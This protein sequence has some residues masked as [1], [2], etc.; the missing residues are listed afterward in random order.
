M[1]F[2]QSQSLDISEIVT[3]TSTKPSSISLEE[4]D[5]TEESIEKKNETP[6]ECNEKKFIIS[7]AD[8]DI[9]RKVNLQDAEVAKEHQETFKELCIEYKDIFSIDSSDIGKTP[10]IEMEIDIDDSPLITQRPY[11]LPLKHAT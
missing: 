10:L 11:T 4:D 1:G 8:I 6:F 5:D 7:P 3:E 9:H 2:M